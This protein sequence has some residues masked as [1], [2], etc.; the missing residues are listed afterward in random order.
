MSLDGY[1]GIRDNCLTSHLASVFCKACSTWFGTF[2]T[3]FGTFHIA[4]LA[5]RCRC[6]FYATFQTCFGIFCKLGTNYETFFLGYATKSCRRRFWGRAFLRLLRGEGLTA[7][8]LRTA[9]AV[10]R[11]VCYKAGRAVGHVGRPTCSVALAPVSVGT[12]WR[13]VAAGANGLAADSTLRP[14]FGGNPPR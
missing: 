5:D 10:A 8:G 7:A 11:F 14:L 1:G 6:T 2:L 4:A 3:Q 9:D 13:T 12:A